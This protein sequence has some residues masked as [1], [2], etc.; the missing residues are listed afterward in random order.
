MPRNKS[1]NKMSQ[2]QRQVADLRQEINPLPKITG[3]VMAGTNRTLYSATKLTKSFGSGSIK[4][5]DIGNFDDNYT[6]IDK[7]SIT[8]P[9][10]VGGTVQWIP[11][12][13]LP[14]TFININSDRIVIPRHTRQTVCLDLPD[15]HTTRLAS[16]ES[17]ELNNFVTVTLSGMTTTPIVY[18]TVHYRTKV[19]V[20]L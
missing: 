3:G 9:P 18:V 15:A 14:T 11:S 13:L 1:N 12:T 16:Q 6:M 4:L 5:T 10:F 19:T 17:S 2:L 8:F 7:I 20:G